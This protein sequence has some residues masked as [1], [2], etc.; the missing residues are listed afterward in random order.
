MIQ[1]ERYRCGR[2]PHHRGAATRHS[3]SPPHQR[4]WD[5]VGDRVQKRVWNIYGVRA[6]PYK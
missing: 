3:F 2:V 6:P 1:K 4:V 5:V